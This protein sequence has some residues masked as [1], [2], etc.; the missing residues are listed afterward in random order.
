MVEQGRLRTGPEATATAAIRCADRHL[1]GRPADRAAGLGHPAA[2]E[3]IVDRRCAQPNRG[4]A[5]QAKP[6]FGPQTLDGGR[7]TGLPAT[8][9]LV[10]PQPE[11]LEPHVVLDRVQQLR[12]AGIQI[13]PGKPDEEHAIDPAPANR[14]DAAR[15]VVVGREPVQAVEH[16]RWGRVE[17]DRQRG[18]IMRPCMLDHATEQVAVGLHH[19]VP[20]AD[21]GDRWPLDGSVQGCAHSVDLLPPSLASGPVAGPDT[22]MPELRG[23]RS[24]LVYT[25]FGGALLRR[26]QRGEALPIVNS[27][28]VVLIDSEQS[29]PLVLDQHLIDPHPGRAHQGSDI[30][31]GQADRNPNA[32]RLSTSPNSSASARSCLAT[33]PVT[34]WSARDCTWALANRNRRERMPT[35]L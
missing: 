11:I 18:E 35:R 32:A 25:G 16:R 17:Q 31:L 19:W 24:Q 26:A 27:D 12:R 1:A 8:E 10:R 13:S 9:G 6:P 22:V 30:A 21:D 7:R 2:R 34:S 28:V 20:D 3:E 4:K 33:R 23:K 29:Q 5:G 14:A 15:Y